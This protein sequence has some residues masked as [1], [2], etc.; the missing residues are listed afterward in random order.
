MTAYAQPRTRRH[1]QGA[2]MRT[3][4]LAL[5]AAAAL[6]VLAVP[7]PAHANHSWNGYHW[8]RTANPF[9]V[10]LGDN[11]TSTWD[12]HLATASSDWSKSTVLDTT[13]AAGGAGNPRPCKATAGR[14]EVCNTTYGNT[15][16][17]SEEHTSELQSRRDLVC[18]LL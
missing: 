5:L 11:V 12:A 4:L 10:Q 15:G 16:W 9:T 14:V 18:R 7:S 3:R 13:V 6:A 1:P 17:R 2:P 8:A